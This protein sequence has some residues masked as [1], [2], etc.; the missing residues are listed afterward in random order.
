MAALIHLDTHVLAW[1]YAGETDR[2]S[3]PARE[4]LRSA[5]PGGTTIAVAPMALLE[6]TY[7]QEIGRLSVGGEEVLAALAP[8]LGLRVDDAPF[9]DVVAIAHRQ[10]WTRDPFDRM[11]AA[12][13]LCSEAEL[14]TADDS[15]RAHVPVARW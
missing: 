14:L 2:L 10:S 12:Q 6:L 11:I 4:A 7:L 15:I 1:L 8:A 9:A 3:P 5:G 13:A